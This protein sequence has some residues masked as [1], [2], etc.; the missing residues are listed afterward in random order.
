[1]KT[2][3]EWLNEL[4][5]ND[6]DALQAW[7]DAEHFECPSDAGEAAIMSVDAFIAEHDAPRADYEQVDGNDVEGGADSREQLE[8]DIDAWLDSMTGW[9]IQARTIKQDIIVWLDRQEAITTRQLSDRQIMQECKDWERWCKDAER[10]CSELQAELEKQTTDYA[11]VIAA[12]IKQMN[13]LAH[14]L[15]ESERFREDMREELSI[16]YDHAHDLLARRDRGLA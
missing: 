13:E 12:Q 14:N 9:S 5:A 8:R 4:A 6:V 10:K 1:M 11:N 7:F 2:N 3:R 15:Q 16:A